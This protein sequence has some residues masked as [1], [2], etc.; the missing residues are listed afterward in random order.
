MREWKVEEGKAEIRGGDHSDAAKG[1]GRKAT[2][3]G[4][5]EL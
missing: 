4:K 5:R 3:R 1:G 2:R